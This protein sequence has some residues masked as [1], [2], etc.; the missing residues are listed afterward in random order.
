MAL[1]LPEGAT[2]YADKAYTDY[3]YEDRLQE[4]KQIRLLAI[5]K[6]NST[7]PHERAVAQALSKGRKR[8]ETPFRQISAKL[9]RRL[10]AVRP[11]GFESKVM[12]VFVVFAIWSTQNERSTD[13]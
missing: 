7:R 13:E 9:P 8:I 5:R 11:S 12:A 2:L 10:H 4:D 1:P 6:S 3:S